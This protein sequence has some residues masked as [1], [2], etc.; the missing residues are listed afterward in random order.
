MIKISKLIIALL[1]LFLL[2]LSLDI[3]Y[4]LDKKRLYK[5]QST[6]IYDRHS[7]L[8]RLHL[9]EDG[10]LR[11]PIDKASISEDIKKTLLSYEDQYFYYHFGVNPFSLA[12]AILF[13]MNNQRTIGASTLTMQVARM[14]HRKKRTLNNKFI[15]IFM[16][17]QLE[18]YYSKDEILEIYL[19]NT[20]YG[21]NIEGFASASFAYFDT[22]VESLSLAQIAYLVSIPKNPNYNKP[23][24]KKRVEQLK[25]RVLTSLYTSAGISMSQYNR[26]IEESI[27]AYRHTLA[28]KAPHLS[29]KFKGG[30]RV[31]T[32]IDLALQESIEML[33][34]KNIKTLKSLDIHNAMALVIDNK[35][36]QILSYVGSQDFNDKKYFGEVDGLEALISP[37]STLKPFVYAKAL[38]KG[39]ITPLKKVYDISLFVNGYK[40]LNYNEEFLGEVTAKEALQLSLNIPAVELDILLGNSSLYSVLT[41]AKISSITHPK[42]YYGSSLVLGGCGITLKELAQLF[43]SFA[44]GGEYENASYL[45]SQTPKKAKR[46]LAKESAY[47]ISKILVDVPRDSFSSSWEYLKNMPKVAFKTG[48]SANAIDM[49][50]I[51]YTPEYTVAVWYGNFSGKQ[52]KA[53][54]KEQKKEEQLTGLKASAPTLLDI[55]KL[56]KPQQWFTK[57]EGVIRKKI[58]QDTIVIGECKEFA[59]DDTIKGIQ[60][61]PPCELMRA[62]VLARLFDTGYIK[63]IQELSSHSCYPLWKSYKPL[64]T[65]PLHGSKQIQNRLLPKELKKTKLQCYS[66]ETNSTIIWMINNQSPIHA[67]SS[68]PMYRYFDTGKYKI[69]CLDQGAKIGN[70]TV[71]IDEI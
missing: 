61:S 25:N 63:S 1:L 5:P 46:I 58:C 32:T 64:I 28:N 35:T 6:L 60:L 36:M 20:P 40:P 49:L 44:N 24:N 62:E 13:N 22:P 68:K 55:F 53:L 43:A 18:Y 51:G 17:L 11:I 57:P 29:S 39:F 52:G 34:Q 70:I 45:L 30:G 41:Q 15:E 54:T 27:E 4:P 2:F 50:A 26:A 8:M 56:L 12:R 65:S 23:S 31:L 59:L 67:F 48:T 21:G 9:S 47:L 69:E 7:E 42:S 14:M 3:L 19:N 37:G 16:A 38:E 33:L 71:E 66:F 10:F